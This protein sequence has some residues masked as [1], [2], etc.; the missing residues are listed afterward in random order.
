[1]P[2]I[3][4]NSLSDPGVEIVASLTEAQLCAMRRPKLPSVEEVLRNARLVVG[5]DSVA[6][7]TNM[8]SLNEGFNSCADRRGPSRCGVLR[9]AGRR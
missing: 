4:I 3:H 7:T 6:N 8:D 5:I 2:V 1:M 9:G